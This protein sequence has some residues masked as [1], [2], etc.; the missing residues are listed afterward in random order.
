MED[1]NEKRSPAMF[2]NVSAAGQRRGA[3]QMV[4]VRLPEELLERLASVG[5]DEGLSMSDT[6]R[7]VLERGLNKGKGQR[8]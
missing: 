3:S 5:N 8:R 2:F 1:M 6:I 4:S 7:L